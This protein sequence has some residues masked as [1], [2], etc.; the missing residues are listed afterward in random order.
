MVWHGALQLVRTKV[1]SV[2]ELAPTAALPAASVPPVL[3]A[4]DAG[5]EGCEGGEGSDDLFLEVLLES[6]GQKPAVLTAKA[7]CGTVI[8]LPSPVGG[9]LLEQDAG[10]NKVGAGGTGGIVWEAGICCA[11]L[12][13]L[14]TAAADADWEEG[15]VKPCSAPSRRGAVRRGARVLELG[16]GT[17]IAGLAAALLGGDATLSDQ[18]NV[19]PLLERNIRANAVRMPARGG[20]AS[21]LVLDWNVVRDRERVLVCAPWDLVLCSDLV[22]GNAYE[23]LLELLVALQRGKTAGEGRPLILFAFQLRE[24]RFPSPG[25]F[26]KLRMHFELQPATEEEWPL[27]LRTEHAQTQLFWLELLSSPA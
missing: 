16:A 7:F 2:I 26:A 15:T 20:A 3:A 24:D 18:R 17:G 19:T 6:M 23:Q 21:A 8:E 14:A 9:V 10:L 12:L 4:L 5:T 27:A 22:F 25:F 13:A 1:F 11:T